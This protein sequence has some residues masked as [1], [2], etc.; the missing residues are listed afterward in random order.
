MPPESAHEPPRRRLVAASNSF[1]VSSS[2]PLPVSTRRPSG[3]KAKEV[4][5]NEFFDWKNFSGSGAPDVAQAP[6]NAATRKLATPVR[7]DE[8]NPFAMTAVAKSAVAR[9]PNILPSPRHFSLFR[10]RF[11]ARKFVMGRV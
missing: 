1:S 4:T 2:A 9:L 3:E 5:Q 6:A 11:P 8:P 10:T 7:T